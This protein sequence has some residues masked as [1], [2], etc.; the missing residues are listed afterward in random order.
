MT[1]G[2]FSRMPECDPAA[3]VI[4]CVNGPAGNEITLALT[5]RKSCGYVG[6]SSYLSIFFSVGTCAAAAAF[7]SSSARSSCT[8][9]RSFSFCD[10]A[11][12]SPWKY[13]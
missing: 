9:R 13:P 1:T 5:G 8:S 10:F 11:V 6:P 7:F 3:M 4:C 12:V 2:V